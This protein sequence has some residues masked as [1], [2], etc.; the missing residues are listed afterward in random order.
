MRKETGGAAFARAGSERK[1]DYGDL[2]K[3]LPQDG[4]SL[5]DYFAA[6]FA[7]A[8][9]SKWNGAH[10]FD[11]GGISYSDC[12]EQAYLLADAMLVARNK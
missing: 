9:V 2:I 10:T 3:S 5:R 7:P 11:E 1:S 6:K 8:I 12:A 4:M